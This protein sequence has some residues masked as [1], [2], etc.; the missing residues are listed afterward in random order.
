M[1]TCLPLSSVTTDGGRSA[2]GCRRL[3]D[4]QLPSASG[5]GGGP[6]SVLVVEPEKNVFGFRGDTA[7]AGGMSCAH[8]SSIGGSAARPTIGH[9]NTRVS[10]I[11]APVAACLIMF[12]L[13]L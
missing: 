5:G 12:E 4:I 3:I 6:P 8:L 9:A 1:R 10:A 13:R 11:V 7:C 2:P